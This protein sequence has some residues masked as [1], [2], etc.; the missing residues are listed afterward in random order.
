MTRTGRVLTLMLV[1]AGSL[2]AG[3]NWTQS[4]VWDFGNT[5]YRMRIGD[6][7]SDGLQRMYCGNRDG[8]VN[9][10]SWESGRW[11]A[12][13]IGRVPDIAYDIAIA[14]GRN[15][16]VSRIYVACG[17][18]HMHEFSYSGGSWTSVDMG[19]M[20]GA[21]MDEVAFGAGRNDGVRRGYVT[22]N[23]GHIFEFSW[24]S[25][26]WSYLDLG[27]IATQMVDIAVGRTGHGRKT[28]V[29][30]SSQAGGIY[31]LTWDNG[32]TSVLIDQLAGH[33][34]AWGIDVGRA[35]GTGESVVDG[36]AEPGNP[37]SCE[38]LDL[39]VTAWC[40]PNVW[41][42][43]WAGGAW[44][45]LSI[46]QVPN[47]PYGADLTLGKGRN[48]CAVRVYESNNDGH[49]Y[50]FSCT[51]GEW[52][53]VDLGSSGSSNLTGVIVGP[54][55][56]DGVQRVYLGCPNGRVLE[57][58]WSGTEDALTTAGAT[59]DSKPG[60]DGLSARPN[61][62]QAQV[63]FS[64]TPGFTGQAD[65]KVCDAGGRTVRR[66]SSSGLIVWDGSD[67]LGHVLPPGVYFARPA[68][69][70]ASAAVRLVKTE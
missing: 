15:D 30:A 46:G 26:A 58:T 42:Y 55:R 64:L 6:C 24:N 62:F 5:V 67:D 70:P 16:C 53:M 40:E 7:R 52:S 48:D 34:A 23:N 18:G 59:A 54:G 35:S 17:D 49:V 22:L 33:D 21:D 51:R 45:K 9:E 41:R 3:G 44:Q 66:L 60:K 37:G 36:R 11:V 20:S 68:G 8:S 29:Y 65:I 12:R 69:S 25:G 27:R 50:E 38:D 19:G 47:Y 56:D 63:A 57:F 4:R 28:H 1:I 32:W 39:Y 61:P 13:Q 2:V 14:A 31:E 43:H 10:I